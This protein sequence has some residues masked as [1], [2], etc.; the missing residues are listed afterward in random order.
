MVNTVI[1]EWD[2]NS[3][4]ASWN[5]DVIAGPS[6]VVEKLGPTKSYSGDIIIYTIKITNIGNETAYNITLEDNLDP[7]LILVST[8]PSGNQSDGKIVWS[9]GTL[10]KDEVFTVF[11]TAKVKDGV[12]NGTRLVNTAVAIW[13][14]EDGGLYTNSSTWITT[15]YT[16]PVIDITKIG[17]SSASPGQEIEYTISI[18][19]LGGTP[20]YNIN[21]SD[22]LPPGTSYVSASPTPSAIGSAYVNWTIA[23]LLPGQNVVIRLTIRTPDSVGDTCIDLINNVSVSWADPKG[24]IK[25]SWDIYTTRVCS[26]P[27]LTIDK[28]GDTIGSLGEELHFVITVSNIGGSPAQNV[29]IWDDLPYNL[30]ITSALPPECSIYG[31][32]IQCNI[33]IIDPGTSIT[34]AYNARVD[35]VSIDGIWVFNNVYANWTYSGVSYGPVTDIHPIRLFA[36]PYAVVNITGP[37]IAY[38]GSTVTYTITL[39]N[40]TLSDLNNIKLVYFVPLIMSYNSSSPTGSYFASNKTVVWSIN[41]LGSGEEK[42]FNVSVVVDPTAIN[43][44]IVINDALVMYPNGSDFDIAATEIIVPSVLPP[45]FPV[46]GVLVAESMNLVKPLLPLIAVLLIGITL[47]IILLH[48][49]GRARQPGYG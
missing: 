4:E 30:S 27:L 33:P 20:A 38:N 2:G 43:G 36:R 28:A 19:N 47:C 13:E 39:R 8:T 1:V 44:T 21:V 15:V 3:V 23:E 45:T 34:I 35:W 9:L 17:P 6:L 5:T 11:V 26:L 37:A 40:P 18:T 46:G 42:T 29:V 25:R 49:I 31:R 14:D 22:I 16:L 10:S 12:P 24:A 32:R 41:E 48:R 7:N